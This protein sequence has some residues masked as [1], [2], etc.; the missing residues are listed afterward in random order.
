[1]LDIPIPGR[2]TATPTRATATATPPTDI[3]L[4]QHLVL[5]SEAA[6]DM[7]RVLVGGSTPL[8]WLPAGARPLA[9]LVDAQDYEDD[10]EEGD[11]ADGYAGH[12]GGVAG[13]W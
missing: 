11:D 13:A 2:P 1:M 7:A 10:G 9:L 6:L 12:F 5:Q 4:R 3:V 8:Q